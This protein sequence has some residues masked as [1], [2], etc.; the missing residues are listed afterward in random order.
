MLRALRADWGAYARASARQENAC[1]PLFRSPCSR[2]CS[3]PCSP[4]RRAAPPPPGSPPRRPHHARSGGHEPDRLGRDRGADRL[5]NATNGY[6]DQGPPSVP[7]S[8]RRS[9]TRRCSRF[10]TGS[11]LRCAGAR[12]SCPCS[13]PAARHGSG[14]SAGRASTPAS[15]RSRRRVPERD[16]H[17]EPALPR[18]EHLGRPGRRVRHAGD[19]V[20]DPEDDGID[21]IAFADFMRSTKAPPRGAISADVRAGERWF[22][23]VGCAICHTLTLVTAPA[24]TPINGGELE[25]PPA[26]ARARDLPRGRPD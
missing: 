24:G 25:V 13:R 14:A 9:P 1:A 22:R 26:L 16:G 6:L 7:A 19:P 11:R 17:H 12:C 8:W 20:E 18:G 4:L 15:S 5:D 3:Q 21:L 10:A 23:D 2:S